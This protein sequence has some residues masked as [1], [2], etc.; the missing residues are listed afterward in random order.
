MDGITR[1]L[2]ES[3]ISLLNPE[4]RWTTFVTRLRNIEVP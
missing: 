1:M 4:A 3:A 2:V